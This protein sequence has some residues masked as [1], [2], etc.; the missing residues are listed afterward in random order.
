MDN[1]PKLPP[2]DMEKILRDAPTITCD[3]CGH[4]AFH[5]VVVFKHLSELL[6][7]NG[8]AGAVPVPTFACD[9]CSAL[10]EAF[11]PNFMKVT[12]VA[13]P[14]VEEVKQSTSTSKIE[15]VR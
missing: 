7:P 2:Q 6:S 5:E 8:K 1:L 9:S 10:N 4:G 11:L 3:Q 12:K 15:I 13:V 14:S